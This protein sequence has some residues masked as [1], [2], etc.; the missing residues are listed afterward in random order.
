MIDTSVLRENDIRGVSGENITE[1][2]AQRVGNAFG[3]Y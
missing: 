2:L 3:T 1:E